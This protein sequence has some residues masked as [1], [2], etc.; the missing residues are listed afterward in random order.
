MIEALPQQLK[1]RILRLSDIT[2]G[3]DIS[4]SS[5]ESSVPSSFLNVTVYLLTVLSYTALYV[6]ADV[7]SDT[8]GSQPMNV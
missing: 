7:T 5:L 3:K 8:V 6:I 4:Y 2:G 1:L